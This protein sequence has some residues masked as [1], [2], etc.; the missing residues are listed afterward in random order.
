MRK[1]FLFLVLLVVAFYAAS[2]RFTVVSS[3]ATTGKY[4]VI[5]VD[6][7]SGKIYPVVGK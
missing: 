7:S 4:L 6:K 3:R 1:W 2:L 5:L